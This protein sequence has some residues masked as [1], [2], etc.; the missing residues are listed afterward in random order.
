MSS[1][2]KLVTFTPQDQLWAKVEAVYVDDTKEVVYLDNRSTKYFLTLAL[3]QGTPEF[4]G[5]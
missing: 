1:G 5:R 4:P 2:I 3:Q